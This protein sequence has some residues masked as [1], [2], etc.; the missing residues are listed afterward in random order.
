M[1]TNTALQLAVLALIDST[2]IGTLVIPIW[3]VL[4]RSTRRL[5]AKLGLYLAT[6]GSFYF[7]LG[8]VLLA[9]GG[10]LVQGYGEGLRSL[11]A[12]P[13]FRWVALMAGIALIA[14]GFSGPWSRAD[15]EKAAHARARRAGVHAPA[16]VPVT[17]GVPVPVGGAGHRAE[18]ESADDAASLTIA[19]AGWGRRIDA[20]L[21]HPAGLVGLALV[22]GLL[23]VPTMLPYLAASGLLVSTG[24]PFGAQ[25]AALA[26]Y[27]ALMLVPA[28]VLL[29]LRR[30]LGARADAW[31]GRVGAK[32][33]GYARESAKWVAAI[34][35]IL[36]VRWAATGPDGVG[37][38]EL[39]GGL[40]GGGR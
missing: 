14:Y 5:G 34:A 31:F 36:V 21:R 23:E 38:G 9:G 1:E 8:L 25:A 2:S 29:V 30:L 16:D 33:G 12:G 24:L 40:V 11:A 7:V 35:G 3:L 4:R 17:A 32:L 10:A 37:L 20:A 39:F 26:L 18:A 19:Q 22:A 13:G 27:C 28:L 15:K 6:L